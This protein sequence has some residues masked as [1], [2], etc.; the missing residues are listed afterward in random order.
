MATYL[1]INK[2]MKSRDLLVK[3]CSAVLVTAYAFQAGTPT[4]DQSKWASSVLLDPT[5]EGKKALRSI[6]AKHKA[7]DVATITAL[8]DTTL[9]SD[10]DTKIAASLVADFGLN[11]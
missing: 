5:S 4:A 2:L 8:P 1:E 6:L 9:Q 10:L 3:V 7:D 11:G